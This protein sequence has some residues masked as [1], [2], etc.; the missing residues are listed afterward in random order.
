MQVIT[1]FIYNKQ[2]KLNISKFTDIK[3]LQIQISRVKLKFGL[4]QGQL[5][6]QVILNKKIYE[7]QDGELPFN[8][9]YL[10]DLIDQIQK[11]NYQMTGP[12]WDKTSITETDQISNLL[13]YDPLQRL[14]LAQVLDHPWIK[15][16]QI[17]LEIPRDTQEKNMPIFLIKKTNQ[18]S[19]LSTKKI[20]Q[21]CFLFVAGEIW[22]R[23]SLQNSSVSKIQEDLKKFKSIDISTYNNQIQVT[24]DSSTNHVYHIDYPFNDDSD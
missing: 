16:M 9:I 24:N 3:N 22:K 2:Q 12:I 13:Q 23:L 1:D 4:T 11:C 17:Q 19:E 21:I 20:Q 14:T 8:S 18:E 5:H 10:N 7:M 6:F 15:N